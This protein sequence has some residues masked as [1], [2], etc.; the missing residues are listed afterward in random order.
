[1]NLSIL[2]EVEFPV[3]EDKALADAAH[4]LGISKED[5]VRKAVAY[6]SAQ[7]VPTLPKT[8]AA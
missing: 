8:H 5:F 6:F 4:R 2:C 1:M 7:S 3:S